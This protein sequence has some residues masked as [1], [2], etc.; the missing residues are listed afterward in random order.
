MIIA[1]CGM[2][3]LLPIGL[4]TLLRG[5]NSTMTP[6]IYLNSL[7][8]SYSATTYSWY[9]CCYTA[10]TTAGIT[11]AM[12][13]TLP[14]H[15]PTAGITVAMTPT[16]PLHVP[17]AGITVAMTPTLPLH[18]PTA[19]IN[20]LLWPLSVQTNTLSSEVSLG[21]FVLVARR[22]I[23]YRIVETQLS[24][25]DAMVCLLRL[26]DLLSYSAHTCKYVYTLKLP[27][28]S[29]QHCEECSLVPRPRKKKRVAWY[30][31]FAHAREFTEYG[32]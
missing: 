27:T 15:V 3:L 7:K 8:P 31:L 21:L 4:S 24:V 17:T 20:I 26:V 5:I 2:S 10:T 22:P 19:G 13:P 29:G 9:H 28:T 12:T 14:L 32:Q 30:P 16:L 11:V 18:V 1:E 25:C 23:P 6:V